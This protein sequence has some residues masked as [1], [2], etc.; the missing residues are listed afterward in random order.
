MGK[1]HGQ[2]IEKAILQ[3]NIGITPQNDGVTNSPFHAAAY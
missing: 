1:E 2:P 3:A